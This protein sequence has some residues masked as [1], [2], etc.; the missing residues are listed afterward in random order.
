MAAPIAM[1]LC[2]ETVDE[3]TAQENWISYMLNP[4]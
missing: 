2:L 1:L 4:V 3:R